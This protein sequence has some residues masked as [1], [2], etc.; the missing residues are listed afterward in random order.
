MT[1]KKISD[2][3]KL[4]RLLL[5]EKFLPNDF[6]NHI[7]ARIPSMNPE[8]VSS[9]NTILEDIMK[10]NIQILKSTNENIEKNIEIIKKKLVN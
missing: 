4:H 5:S 6:K 3:L 1:N 8:T 7:L 9:I 10:T 2:I